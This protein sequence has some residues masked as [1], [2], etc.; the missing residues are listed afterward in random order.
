MQVFRGETATVALCFFSHGDADGY[1]AS[2][3]DRYAVATAQTL[4]TQIE[5]ACVKPTP[6]CAKHNIGAHFW[7]GTQLFTT[8][9][10]LAFR[11]EIQ[12]NDLFA[13]HLAATQCHIQ[14]QS[15]HAHATQRFQ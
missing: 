12:G 7:Q 4:L 13:V 11:M 10:C 6:F 8:V 1:A 14:V 5:V 15:E 3:N 2:L 9:K